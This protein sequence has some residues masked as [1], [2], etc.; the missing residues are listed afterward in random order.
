[1][2]VLATVLYEDQR[3]PQKTRFGPHALV[4]AC[5]ADETGSDRW[6]LEKRIEGIPKKGDSKLL[7]AH[8]EARDQILHAASAADVAVRRAIL[9]AVPSFARL[10]RGLV[11]RLN[12]A[13]ERGGREG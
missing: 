9:A 2:K 3:A 8:P 7:R 12:A 4:I 13:G 10:V 6:A 1:V 11:V 5:V